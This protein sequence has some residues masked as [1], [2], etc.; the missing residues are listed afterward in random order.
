MK[1]A[2]VGAHP[3][4]RLDAPYDDPNWEI[5]TCSQKNE[6]ELP[7]QDLWFELHDREAIDRNGPYIEFLRELPRVFMRERFSDIPG[8]VS[9]P[10]DTMTRLFGRGFFTG[11]MAYMAAWAVHAHPPE[12]GIWGVEPGNAEFARA[13]AG[14]QHFIFMAEREGVKVTCQDHLRE[15]RLYAYE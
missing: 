3:G 8:S 14:L 7:R 12:I 1:V 11:T 2:L 15:G 9:Y 4:S 5:W 13:R 10:L 6:N